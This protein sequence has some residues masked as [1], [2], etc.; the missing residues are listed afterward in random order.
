LNHTKNHT[1]N[2]TRAK[3][4]RA[5]ICICL[6]IDEIMKPD[7]DTI[8]GQLRSIK[9]ALEKPYGV[10]RIGIFGSVARNEA[11]DE[12][13]IDIVVEMR[14][15]LF[16]RAELKSA[17]TTLLGREVDIVRYRP[18]MNERL[19]KRIENEALYV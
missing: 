4:H 8:L 6:A 10:I 12:S 3:R 2:P 15:D 17:L 9:P 19:K 13:D 1:S 5:A 11:G 14:P 18:R 7:R 16:K